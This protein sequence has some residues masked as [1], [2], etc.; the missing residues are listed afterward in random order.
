MPCLQGICTRTYFFLTV[1]FHPHPCEILSC[2]IFQTR[3]R[4]VVVVVMGAQVLVT[5]PDPS[6]IFVVVFANMM[7][8]EGTTTK[9]AKGH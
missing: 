7:M 2:S 6:A 1:K 9:V 8:Q 5:R 3:K 4:V